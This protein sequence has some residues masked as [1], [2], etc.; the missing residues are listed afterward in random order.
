M[1]LDLTWDTED[2]S[3]YGIYALHILIQK[4]CRWS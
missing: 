4:D 1:Q 2:G 3:N